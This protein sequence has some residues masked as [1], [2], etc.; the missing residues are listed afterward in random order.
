MIF[1]CLMEQYI[2]GF[3]SKTLDKYLKDSE[4]LYSQYISYVPKYV[5]G[6]TIGT[7]IGPGAAGVAFFYK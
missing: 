4:H 5:L 2:S 7:H 3:D 6:G 1:Q